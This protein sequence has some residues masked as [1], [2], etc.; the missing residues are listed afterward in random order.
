MSGLVKDLMTKEIL[1]VLPENTVEEAAIL[2]YENDIGS[3]PVV[4]E[5]Q[6]K[7][8]LTDRDIV[9]RCIAK[10]KSVDKTKISEVMSNYVFFIE[11][12]QTVSEAINMMAE[13]KVRRLPV[14]T[15]GQIEGIISLADIARVHSEKEVGDAISK[16]SF[17]DE[18]WWK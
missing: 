11:P 16:I 17:P 5:G 6:L 10:G 2:M 7:G 15:K 13:K 18:K 8:I 3:V 12:T 14:A 4:F 9:I 1:A